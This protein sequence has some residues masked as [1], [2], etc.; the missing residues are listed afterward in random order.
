MYSIF[1]KGIT[2]FE[3]LIVIAIIGIIVA[4]SVSQ[5]SKVRVIQILQNTGEDIVS[6]S[7][8]AKTQTLASLDSSEYG[9]HFQSDKIVIFKG[10]SYNQNDS[11]NEIINVL[12]PAT[13][14]EIS[15]SGG[16]SDFY[17]N[18]LTG[19]PS[20]TGTIKISISSDA[21][22]NKTINISATGSASL[23]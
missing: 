13:I 9:V 3:V 17:F 5:F 21:N 22:L 4:I 8:K 7:N 20:K 14:S 10:T 23:N 6:A 2:L 12:S 11:S 15:L 1:K 19:T 16:G 18:R